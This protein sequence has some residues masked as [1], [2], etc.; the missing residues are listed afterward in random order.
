L[1]TDLAGEALGGFGQTVRLNLSQDS[2]Q[3]MLRGGLGQRISVPR[4]ANAAWLR[5]GLRD[6]RS[7]RVGSIKISLSQ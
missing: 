3:R 6:E 2:M 1:Q 7:G 5:I 4:Q